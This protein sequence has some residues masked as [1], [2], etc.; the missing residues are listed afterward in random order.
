MNRL[1]TTRTILTSLALIVLI[2]LSVATKAD[3]TSI[4]CDI[5]TKW[6]CSETGC[7]TATPT[8]YNL[9]NFDTAKYSRCDQKGC[10]AYEVTVTRS[11]NYLNILAPQKSMLAKLGG[12]NLEHFTEVVTLGTVVL[13]SHG[14]CEK[15]D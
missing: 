8:I 14:K 9:M 3:A 12:S 13:V 10:D 6:S 15:I 11:G 4:R 5:A 1:T 7:K 2:N